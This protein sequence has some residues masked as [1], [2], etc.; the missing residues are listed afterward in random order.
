MP[1]ARTKPAAAQGSAL[2]QATEHAVQ[3]AMKAG[4]AQADA[5]LESA[6]LFRVDTH[7]GEIENLKQSDT[8]GLGLRVFVEHRTALVYTS[9]LRPAA[10]TDLAAR[11]V[12]L[13]RQSAPD[14]AAGLPDTPPGTSGT[15]ESLGLFDP[16]IVALPT[17]R[18]IAM[19]K[20]MEQ[21]ALGYDK[22]ILRTDGCSVTTAIGDTYLASSAG[23]TLNYQG[24]SVS[25]FVNPLA[26]DGPR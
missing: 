6:R 3:A 2:G 8:R 14:P 4:A 21:S 17:E 23:P 7:Q 5:L 26:D 20:A 13:A 11:A 12:A 1:E 24:T 18:K 15:S 22:R 9:D 16:A 25:A 19:C 10:L